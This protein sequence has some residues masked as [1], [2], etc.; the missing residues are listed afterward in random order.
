MKKPGLRPTR[1]RDVRAAVMREI[2]KDHSSDP[3]TLV[4]EELGIEHGMCRVDVAVING[5]IHGYE[6]KSD[7]DTLVRLPAQIAAYSRSLDRATVVV[8]SLHLESVLAL[9]PDWWGVSVAV[10]TDDE[11]VSIAVHRCERE[12][13]EPSVFH[14]AHLLWRSEAVE[15]LRGCGAASGALRANRQQLYT[16]L[17]EALPPAEL[18]LMVR[19]TVKTR[20]TWRRPA[21]LS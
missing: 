17:L 10:P 2:H 6:L 13:P 20:E 5:T 16:M 1:E 3:D 9:V 8:G 18:R 14:M 12:N 19:E 4:V 15:I 7:S 21:R 11:T